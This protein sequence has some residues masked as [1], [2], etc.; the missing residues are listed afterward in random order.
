MSNGY[1]RPSGLGGFSLFPPVI[2][3]LLI[4]NVAVF[5]LQT[6]IE[7]TIIAGMPGWLFINEQFA[8][9]PISGG[10]LIQGVPFEFNF[11]IWQLITYQFLHGSFT[12]LFFNM[13][14]IW[15]FGVELENIWGSQKFLIFYLTCG[16]G[17]GLMH[18]FLTPIIAGSN[19]WTVG[20]SGAVYGVLV[21]FAMMFPDRYIYIYFL[22]PVR[23]KYLIAFY[24]IFEFMAI[25]S[26]DMVAHLAHIGGALFGFIF[27]LLNN[28]KIINIGDV[29]SKPRSK[30]KFRRPSDYKREGKI[31]EDADYYEITKK[32]GE[33]DYETS[34]EEIDVILDKIS[35][36]GYQNLT[37]RE[38]KILF[39]A[40]KKK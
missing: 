32:S 2:K 36:S 3:N 37:D 21:A 29:F 9:N 20:A 1:Y 30:N 7:R 4:I 5:L 16:V 34:Q 6:I 26:S 10:Y 40:S 8:L 17:A 18:I 38:K 13:F 24:I 22:F 14:A 15:M 28:K 25:G 12:H 31:I 19:T 35:Q 33:D 27:V 23:A 39:E 11:Q